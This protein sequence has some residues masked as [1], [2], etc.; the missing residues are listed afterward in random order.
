M[1]KQRIMLGN[2]QWQVLVYYKVNRQSAPEIADILHQLK[3]KKS[4]IED[5]IESM[6]NEKNSGFTLTNSDY[7]TSI[8][9]ISSTTSNEQ[10]INTIVHESKHVQSHI[11]EYYN[12]DESGE[13]AAYLIG[14]L[15]QQMYKV[16]KNALI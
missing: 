9:C 3:C 2:N 14:Y 5:S 7:H 16:F 8:V 1:M 15:V 11:C 10:F 6:L 13:Q 12:I 4:D